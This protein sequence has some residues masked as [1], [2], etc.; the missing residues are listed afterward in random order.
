MKL[1]ILSSSLL[2]LIIIGLRFL[3]KGKIS[4]RVQYVLWLIVLLRLLIPFS[5]GRSP[6]SV[7]NVLPASMP[8]LVQPQQKI[9]QEYQP[10][11]G[12][13]TAAPAGQTVQQTTSVSTGEF[14]IVPS[15][16]TVPQTTSV[17]VTVSRSID[18]GKLLR[19]IWMIGA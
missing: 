1:W 3:L 6:V 19:M 13:Y 5:V 2:I 8:V 9:E 11:S 10:F 17:E 16:Q 18:F 4:F 15:E 12:E 7:E 14:T